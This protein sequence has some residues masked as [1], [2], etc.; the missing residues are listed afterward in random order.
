[1]FRVVTVGRE[2][3][4]GGAA[5]ARQVAQR[6]SW[7]LLDGALV[8]DVAARA[9]IDPDLARKY[10]EAVDP[11]LHRVSRAALWQGAFEG[12]A[13]VG[14]GD[15]LDA[16]TMARLAATLIEQAHAEG[17]CVIVG[18]GGQCVLQNRPDA[19]HVYIYAPWSERVARVRARAPGLADPEEHIRSVDR[20]R[21]EYVRRNYGCSWAD[22]HL[23]HLLISSQLGEGPAASLIAAA[24]A[25]VKP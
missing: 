10:D 11:W 6:L 17:N 14:E 18:R 23:Y 4:S 1:M 21:S 22:P 3:G 16:E 5:I 24:V 20:T 7:K 2:F 12:V 19:F 25:S 9:K 13:S 8:R 15:F